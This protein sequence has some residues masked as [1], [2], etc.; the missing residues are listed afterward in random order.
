MRTLN[1]DYKSKHDFEKRG[2]VLAGIIEDPNKNVFSQ[3]NEIA[4]GFLDEYT[5][6]DHWI[7]FHES[8]KQWVIYYKPGYECVID[9][10]YK[11]TNY[12]SAS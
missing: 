11:V 5:L 2:P 3:I 9:Q 1:T 12:I 4:P 10:G 8:W 7:I 6:L